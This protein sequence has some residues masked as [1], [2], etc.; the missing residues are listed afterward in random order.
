MAAISNNNTHICCHFRDELIA[1][2]NQLSL[3]N[4]KKHWPELRNSMRNS[5]NLPVYVNKYA[6]IR[7]NCPQLI[8]DKILAINNTSNEV[9]VETIDSNSNVSGSNPYVH[10]NALEELECPL[11][12]IISLIPHPLNS[13][14]TWINAD[15]TGSKPTNIK[16]IL[17]DDCRLIDDIANIVIQYSTRAL[18]VHPQMTI[19]CSN[20][21]NKEHLL[22]AQILLIEHYQPDYSSL[23]QY[24]N[25][26]FNVS[27]AENEA[28]N[29]N[30]MFT[31]N[32]ALLFECNHF[33][34]RLFVKFGATLWTKQYAYP[35]NNFTDASCIRLEFASV[36]EADQS[37]RITGSGRD[38]VGAFDI[39]GFYYLTLRTLKFR[40]FY[41]AHRVE[42]SAQ[43][44][45]AT[46]E[47]K[48]RWQTSSN[49]GGEFRMKLGYNKEK[50]D[51]IFQDFHSL[52]LNPSSSLDD[53]K[54]LSKIEIFPSIPNNTAYTMA[55]LT[56]TFHN[57]L[58]ARIRY[59]E[60]RQYMD[61]YVD[62]HEENSFQ[63]LDADQTSQ[64][65]T[66]D[67]IELNA[68]N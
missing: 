6:I 14:C 3:E 1:Q 59:L 24:Y 13:T 32:A 16:Q 43:F 50:P 26:H 22:P 55:S 33:P 61:A 56:D 21:I 38:S 60:S 44:D 68:T 34:S 2:V 20:S 15:W 65:P 42:Y 62:L 18:C 27:E 45:C 53:E 8:I 30:K 63:L 28:H 40:K 46:L 4:H 19:L 57:Q 5:N 39:R 54:F 9:I 52:G 47:F 51:D 17:I 7:S 49:W 35:G 64:L 29:S 67:T 58:F 25:K 11:D 66:K 23:I 36:N 12:D 41:R 48:G 37:Q 31:K 10:D